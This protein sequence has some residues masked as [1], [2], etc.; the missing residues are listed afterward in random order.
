MNRGSAASSLIFSLSMISL[1]Q[2]PSS[3][4]S[5][6]ALFFKSI[7]PI[8]SGN[9]TVTHRSPFGDQIRH[10]SLPHM[11]I[12]RAEM[13]MNVCSTVSLGANFL[14]LNCQSLVK[15]SGLSDVHRHPFSRF[16][17]LRENDVASYFPKLHFYRMYPISIRP[18]RRSGPVNV[19]STHFSPSLPRSLILVGLDL[20]WQLA[21][22]IVPRR[23]TTHNLGKMV[24][25]SCLKLSIDR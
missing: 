12:R 6:K 11:L 1:P 9:S 13:H 23:G 15:I 22:W 16:S 20:D 7:S 10:F 14:L 8:P 18:S 19:R 5:K 3:L 21:E 17:L 2:N 4:L 24:V 25:H